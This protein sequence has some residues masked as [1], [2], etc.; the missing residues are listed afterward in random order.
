MTTDTVGGVWVYSM[1]LCRALQKY[2]VEIHLAAMGAW[3]SE[4][5]QKEVSAL[6]NVTLY[7]SDFKLEWMQDPWEDVEK[8]KKWITSIYHTVRPDVVHF[9][10]YAQIE[11]FWDC[12]IVTVFHSCVQT[13]WQAVKGTTAPANWNQYTQLVKDSLQESD[14][15]VTPTKAILKEAREAHHFTTATKV[16]HNGREVEFSEEKE[17]ENFILCMGRLWDEGKN[18][19]LL[20][21]I[22]QRLPWPVYIAGDNVNPNTGEEVEVPNVNFLGELP[23]AEVWDW[24][25]RAAIFASPT[26]YEP[27]GIAILEAAKA[28]CA[29]AVSDLET[30]KEL[31]HEAAAFFDPNNPKQ[32]TK[33]I[34]ELINNEE[35]RQEL[36]AAAKKRSEDYN[37]KKMAEAYFSLYKEL[38]TET[39]TKQLSN[40]L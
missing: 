1:E 15:V 5:Q 24:M 37:S 29:L 23:E 19:N 38:L 25:Q 28:N 10:N 36:A 14:V 39:K 16:I 26:K 7:K 20:S 2:G 32:T 3:P 13:W 34:L 8:A 12:P 6:E 21:S 35:R 11:N 27:F 40:S 18:L 4:D 33:R 31:W 30:L 9:N 17:K 22:A